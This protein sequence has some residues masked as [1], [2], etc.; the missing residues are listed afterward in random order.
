M[1]W[2]LVFVG[3]SLWV[4]PA[5][6]ILLCVECMRVCVCVCA[7]V[8]VRVR[9]R[10]RVCVRVYTYIV[11]IKLHIRKHIQAYIYNI[12]HRDLP[13]SAVAAAARCADHPPQRS[14][15]IHASRLTFNFILSTELLQYR[16]DQSFVLAAVST[17]LACKSRR[18]RPISGRPM[19]DQRTAPTGDVAY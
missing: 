1:G 17:R 12:S 7:C 8:R 19:D 3:Y 14:A 10:V 11:Y 2:W 9:V 5:T 18:D 16:S 13:A 4:K 6:N 15:N